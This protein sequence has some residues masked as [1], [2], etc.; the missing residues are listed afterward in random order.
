MKKVKALKEVLHY[1]LLE[2]GAKKLDNN[3]TYLFLKP[4]LS[5]KEIESGHKYTISKVKTEPDIVVQ[6]YRYNVDGEVSE[7]GIIDIPWDIYKK[8]YEVV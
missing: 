5:I 7:E 2:K 1:I 8:D 4:T 3:D 6:A